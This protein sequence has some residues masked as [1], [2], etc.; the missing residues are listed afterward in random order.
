[1]LFLS[2]LNE[3]LEGL[4]A[5]TEE[6]SRLPQA[7]R[8]D[9]IQEKVE[10]L[11]TRSELLARDL[12]QLLLDSGLMS[13]LIGGPLPKGEIEDN[14]EYVFRGLV[15]VLRARLSHFQSGLEDRLPTALADL[16]S[17][18]DRRGEASLAARCR[19]LARRIAGGAIPPGGD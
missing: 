19:E 7:G 14:F 5:D 1:M 13:V 15:D 17:A 3:E 4:L 10:T 6:L 2:N 18:L 11:L 8:T 9:D 12:D 16:G